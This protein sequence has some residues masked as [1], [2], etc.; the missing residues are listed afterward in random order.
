MTINKQLFGLI[1]GSHC[2]VPSSV[3]LPW[4][5]WSKKLGQM[6]VVQLLQE[7][8]VINS[9]SRSL[10]LLYLSVRKSFFYTFIFE[11]QNQFAKNNDIISHRA[12]CFLINKCLYVYISVFVP[13]RLLIIVYLS[14]HQNTGIIIREKNNSLI[15]EYH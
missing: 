12:A 11:N 5:I 7:A 10:T 4:D 9:R 3:N 15:L 13:I 14:P 6:C 2:R 8:S 1:T